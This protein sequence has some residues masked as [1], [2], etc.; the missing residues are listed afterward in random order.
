MANPSA[1]GINRD[2]INTGMKPQAIQSISFKTY[3]ANLFS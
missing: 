3:L 1:W 2:A